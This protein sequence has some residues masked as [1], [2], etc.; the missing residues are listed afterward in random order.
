MSQP[1]VKEKG[2]WGTYPFL[3]KAHR[4][5]ALIT[6]PSAGQNFIHMTLL[7]ARESGKYGFYSQRP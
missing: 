4:E 5:T 7:A 3:F 2:G 6:P 1:V